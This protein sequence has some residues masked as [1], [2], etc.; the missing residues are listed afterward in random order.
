[1]GAVNDYAKL[2]VKADES[3]DGLLQLHEL[4]SAAA[5][6]GV[7]VAVLELPDGQVDKKTFV[8]KCTQVLG[9]DRKVVIKF[10]QARRRVLFVKKSTFT[11]AKSGTIRV[12]IVAVMTCVSM[13]DIQQWQR[14]RDARKT[15]KLDSRFVIQTLLAPPEDDIK[16]AVEQGEGGLKGFVKEY[17]PEGITLGHRVLVMDKADRN[18]Q[19][20][21][22][23][24]RPNLNKIRGYIQE[25]LEALG[26]LHSKGLAHCD[27]KAL[28]VVRLARDN[29]LRLI[30][31]D[32]AARIMHEVSEK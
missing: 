31:L 26:H 32:A 7:S 29:G 13:Q 11:P 20:I 6:L 4:E 9:A 17:L 14:E 3:K 10:M 15:Q 30:D 23:K 19:E 18:L 16:A 28:N 1:M 27:V 2:F 5:K 8:A 24:E 12:W 22:Q 21:F 25:V